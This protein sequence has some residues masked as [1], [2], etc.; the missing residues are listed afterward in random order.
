MAAP[1]IEGF[2]NWS[3]FPRN[4]VQ[5]ADLDSTVGVLVTPDAN[6]GM[7]ISHVVF[8]NSTGATRVVNVFEGF[9]G[10]TLIHKVTLPAGNSAVLMGFQTTAGRDGLFFA[11]NAS[12]LAGVYLTVF[13]E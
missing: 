6:A 7:A 8:S 1:F 5:V 12:D 3:E 2:N 10:S 11:D 4:Y 13:F 9:D